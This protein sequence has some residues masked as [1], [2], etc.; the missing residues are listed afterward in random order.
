MAGSIREALTEAIAKHEGEAED[1]IKNTEIGGSDED[2]TEPVGATPQEDSDSPTLAPE[3]ESE[4]PTE[5]VEGKAEGEEKPATKPAEK[6]AKEVTPEGEAKAKASK[7]PQ[8][9]S[10]KARE[11]FSK[12]SPIAQAEILKRETEIQR[13]LSQSANSRRFTDDF[14]KMI[15]PFAGLM[16]A[17]GAKTPLEAVDNLIKTAASLSLGSTLQKA[18]VAANIIKTYGVDLATL[19]S[20]L[21]G[22]PRAPQPSGEGGGGMNSD[23]ASALDAKL[24]PIM[25][26]MGRM[27]GV[28]QQT[29]QQTQQ[30]ADSYVEQFAAKP[31]VSE[32]FEDLREDMADLMETAARRGRKLTIEQA[33]NQAAGL[34]PDISNILTK[35][36][37]MKASKENA[38]NVERSRRAASSIPAGGP[39]GTGKAG[40]KDLRGAISDAVDKHWNT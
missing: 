17:Q 1:E 36:A 22:Q 21:S 40:A 33:F 10:P 4:E 29:E 19:D 13:G 30:Q 15:A 20:V 24:A 11:E 5:P 34:H 38:T 16:Q 28:A 9:W 2:S 37:A 23:F 12:I 27:Q 32:F 8:S 25:Q 18:Q 7:A 39:N 31:E 26:F 3:G 14:H 35:R 6:Q